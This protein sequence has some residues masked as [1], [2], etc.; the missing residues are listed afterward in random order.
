M[1]VHC[2]HVCVYRSK[3]ICFYTQTQPACFDNFQ[4][5]KPSVSNMIMPH[6]TNVLS[7]WIRLSSRICLK[8]KWLNS[9][10]LT[11]LA[12]PTHSLNIIMLECSFFLIFHA[13]HHIS[14]HRFSGHSSASTPISVSFYSYKIYFIYLKGRA[15][16]EKGKNRDL[17]PVD[18]LPIWMVLG[19]TE[20]KN[21]Q[22]H[23]GLPGGYRSPKASCSCFP[24][25]NN[26]KLDKK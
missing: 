8:Q 12:F 18:I 5:A 4:K 3:S 13:L 21:Q 20:A 2:A 25:C 22:L 19:Q 26:R 6:P 23:L 11:F 1:R 17:L 9:R 24:W 10:S 14:S 7:V 15:S 16:K